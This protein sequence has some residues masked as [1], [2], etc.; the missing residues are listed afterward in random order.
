MSNVLGEDK[1]QSVLALGRLGWSLRRIEEWTRV[2]R[3]S[4]SAYLKA[5]GIAVRGKGGRPGTKPATTR[6]VST[7][8]GAKPAITRG[9]STDSGASPGPTPPG[10]APAASAC[11]PFRERITEAVSHDRNAK[12]IWQDLVDGIAPIRGTVPLRCHSRGSVLAFEG[13]RVQW[14]R[15]CLGWGP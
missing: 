5:A 15:A 9:V 11:E 2:R 12:A 8:P 4:A 13:H 3:E 1:R 7:D 10:R 14:T 6:G